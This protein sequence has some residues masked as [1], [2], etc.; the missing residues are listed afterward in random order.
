MCAATVLASR[1]EAH[2]AV[3]SLLLFAGS[4]FALLPTIRRP[5]LA[6]FELALCAVAW[7]PL[8]TGLLAVIT[9]LLLAVTFGAPAAL[10]GAGKYKKYVRVVTKAMRCSSRAQ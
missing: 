4:W 2:A 5:A 10:L 7:A 3:S 9:I 8:G 1:L 6:P